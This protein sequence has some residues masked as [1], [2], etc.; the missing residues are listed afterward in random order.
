[1]FRTTQQAQDRLAIIGG[2]DM[3]KSDRGFGFDGGYAV[4]VH[5]NITMKPLCVINTC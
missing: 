5:E 3:G 2:G 4:C 1:M